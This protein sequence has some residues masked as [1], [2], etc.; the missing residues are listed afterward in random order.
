MARQLPALVARRCRGQDASMPIRMNEWGL[1]AYPS[2]MLQV[3]LGGIAG[4]GDAAR[5][6]GHSLE[7]VGSTVAET[8]QMYDRVQA[9]GEEAL[10]QRGVQK[11]A[12]ETQQELLERGGVQDWAS[13]W[14]QVSLPKIEPLLKEISESRREQ[15]R[16]YA[17][18]TL[19]KASMDARRTY[20][21]REISRARSRWQDMVDD[22]AR[23]GDAEAA[24]ACLRSGREIFVP[25]ADMEA[26]ETSLRSRCQAADWQSR[27]QAQPLETL[28]AW[29]DESANRPS[30]PRDY[31]AV[32]QAAAETRRALRWELGNEYAASLLRGSAP[33][34][35]GLQAAAGA[36]LITLPSVPEEGRADEADWMCRMDEREDD[37]VSLA[38]WRLRIASMP[39]ETA[40]KR[41]LMQYLEEG[42]AVPRA[43]R[44]E[45]SSRMWNLYRSGVFGCAGDAVAQQRM[46]RLLREGRRQLRSDKPEA[47]QEWMQKLQVKEPSWVC[48]E[49]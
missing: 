28:T 5:A 8:L 48:F 21:L 47:L 49:A 33:S 44:C 12:A 45:L 41:R 14:Q 20:E 15:A 2:Q 29:N 16:Q 18:E 4:I 6:V 1:K 24:V 30:E 25:E 23:R 10:L 22:A 13:S 3:P 36:G 19:Q 9:K 34:G 37:D 32:E 40:Q 11:I 17:E 27:L 38:D 46:A 42:R 39:G 7:S 31:E 43:Q 35:A 26:R